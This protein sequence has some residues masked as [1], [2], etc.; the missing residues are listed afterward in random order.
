[1]KVLR[2]NNVFILEEDPRG[3]LEPNV[4]ALEAERE[5]REKIST[6]LELLDQTIPEHNILCVFHLAELT[7]SY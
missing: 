5:R 6:W 7:T 1:M 4:N 3:H 2:N